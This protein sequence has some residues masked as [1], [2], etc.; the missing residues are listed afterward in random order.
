MSEYNWHN[1]KIIALGK[2]EPN[3]IEIELTS[4]RRETNP[5]V[6]KA[7]EQSW[8]DATKGRIGVGLL[9]FRSTTVYRLESA[10]AVENALKLVIG[11]VEF[12][13][14][15][16]TNATNP[17][18]GDIFGSNFLANGML[19]Q[20]LIKTNDGNFIFG[21]RNDGE[22]VGYEKLAIFGGSLEKENE[23]SGKK[24][25]V[26][27]KDS[28]DIFEMMRQEI[29]DE[30]GVKDESIESIKL[31]SLFQDWK[32]YPVLLFQIELN[33]SP[34]DLNDIFKGHVTDEHN[35]I[36]FMS[37]EMLETEI[38][39]TEERF[40]DLTLASLEILSKSSPE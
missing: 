26:V 37:S 5:I 24:E 27:I 12:R 20:G 19:V 6:E 29:R 40:S 39:T 8:Q 30:L 18:L 17:I 4:N 14:L 22:R 33:L 21:K 16:G 2:F 34:I 10:Q 11:E 32:Y 35:G 28:S 23:L 1:Y 38:E 3:S 31:V 9:P 7:I 25:G 36:E 15:Q 13:E